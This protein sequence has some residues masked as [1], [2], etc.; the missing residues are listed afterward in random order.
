MRAALLA[1]LR[2]YFLGAYLSFIALF[3]WLQPQ[4]YLAMKVI[5]PV[6]S[7]LFFV[8][9]GRY[10]AGN[11]DASFYVIGNALH[12]AS[13]SGIFGVAMTIE[14]DRWNGTL[15]YLFAAP[16]NRL[17]LFL[18][19]AFMHILDGALGVTAGLIWG[20]LLFGLDLSAASPTALLLTILVAT[21]STSGLGLVLGALG[22][23]TR[24]ALFIS[25][26][27]YALLWIFSGANLQLSAL[28]AWA[29][30]L[31][32]A[33]P[34]TRSITAARAIIAGAPLQEIAPLLALDLLVGIAYAL[35][36]FLLFRAFEFQARRHGALETF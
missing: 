11:D 4:A 17:F 3:S 6:T 12:A 34:L 15:P 8:L 27:V 31:S 24:N 22:L 2:L 1:Y 20:I 13:I 16:A 18:G 35:A 19:R 10:V 30:T 21:L 26:L 9:L 36:G 33:I 32:Q 5:T 28:P 23:I 7:M 14:G 25:N 29:Q